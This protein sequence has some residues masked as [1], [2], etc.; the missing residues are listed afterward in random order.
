MTDS[1][2]FILVS[3][4]VLVLV[5][6]L[7]RVLMLVRV[8]VRVFCFKFFCECVGFT[9]GNTKIQLTR[10]CLTFGIANHTT[11]N[12]KPQTHPLIHPKKT[13]I[14]LHTHSYLQS[15]WC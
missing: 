4:R 1:A 2:T 6:V 12:T 7:V 8:L 10:G 15:E 14:Q 9:R 5:L 11:T 13:N 3:G